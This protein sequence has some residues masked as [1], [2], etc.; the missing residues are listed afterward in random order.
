MTDDKARR[1]MVVEEIGSQAASD[2]QEPLEEIKEGVEKLQGITEH[3]SDD[4]KESTEVQKE[5][6][7]AAEKVE[8]TVPTPLTGQEYLPP[9]PQRSNGTNPLVIIIPGILLLGALLGGIV[10]YQKNI[11]NQPAVTPTPTDNPITAVATPTASSSATVDLTKYT[12]NIFNGSGIGGEAGRAKDLLT[13][14]GFKVGTTANAATY[15]FTKTIIKAKSTVDPA[16]I[17]KLSATLGKNYIVD[18]AQVLA[19]T[20]KDDVEVTVGSSKAN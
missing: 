20:A 17:A 15:N 18:T 14:A 2:I 1:R 16:Y 3:M 8:P 4:V 5:I 9:T 10:F 6:V 7:E 11:S 12:V 13:T 19:A